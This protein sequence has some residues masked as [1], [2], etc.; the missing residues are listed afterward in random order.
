MSP[1]SKNR[2]TAADKRLMQGGL[3]LRLRLIVADAQ[4]LAR[5]KAVATDAI[6]PFDVGHRNIVAAGNRSQSVAAAH[7]VA[8]FTAAVAAVLLLATV[9]LLT[10]IGRSLATVGS[11]L[12]RIAGSGGLTRWCIDGNRLL[13]HDFQCLTAPQGVAAQIV[14]AFE[15][16]HIG[17]V[18]AGDLNQGFA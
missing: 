1:L 15:G 13:L 5:V 8:D 18:T 4:F 17:I 12:T 3:Q 7:G 2:H 6:L 14:V 16:C 9:L 10:V 11:G